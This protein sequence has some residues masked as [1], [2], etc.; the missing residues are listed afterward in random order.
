MAGEE[1]PGKGFKPPL[2]PEEGYQTVRLIEVEE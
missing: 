2:K 1:R